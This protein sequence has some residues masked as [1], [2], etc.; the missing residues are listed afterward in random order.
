MTDPITEASETPRTAEGPR[1]QAG[2]MLY[3]FWAL[4]RSLY[5]GV[6]EQ[7]D[8]VADRPEVVVLCGSTRFYDMFQAANYDPEARS[9]RR[10]RSTNSTSETPTLPT[11]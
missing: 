4:H 9:R 8:A 10:R 3:G 7:E 1:T 11:R 5:H 2:M 6:D